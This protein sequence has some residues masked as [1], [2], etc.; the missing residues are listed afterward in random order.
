MLAAATSIAAI[1]GHGH[2]GGLGSMV[3]AHGVQ[4][5]VLGVHYASDVIAGLLAG[6]RHYRRRPSSTTSG[7]SASAAARSFNRCASMARALASC[8]FLR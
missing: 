7:W 4:P 5:L 6:V 3:C 1:D 8:P 2:R